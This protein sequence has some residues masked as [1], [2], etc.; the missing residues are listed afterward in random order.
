MYC[1]APVEADI[2]VIF[3]SF[4]LKAKE[5]AYLAFILDITPRLT[6]GLGYLV[7]SRVFQIASFINCYSR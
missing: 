3:D 2:R 6:L 5:G 7:R 4:F 1:R